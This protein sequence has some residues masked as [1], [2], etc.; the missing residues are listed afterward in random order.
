MSGVCAL[1]AG[2]CRL[3]REGHNTERVQ[4]ES[5]AFMDTDIR[6]GEAF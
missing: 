6:N 4:R 5:G 3:T 2:V 1:R